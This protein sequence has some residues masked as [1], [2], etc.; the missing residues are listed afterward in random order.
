VLVFS[1][2]RIDKLIDAAVSINLE[3]ESEAVDEASIGPEILAR[4]KMLHKKTGKWNLFPYKLKPYEWV[5]PRLAIKAFFEYQP[6]SH[7]KGK[8]HE[9]LQAAISSDSICAVISDRSRLY[10]DCE[11]LERLVEALWVIRIT[12]L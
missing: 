6:I 4:V 11:H 5:Y 1:F 10:L 2:E 8:L 12:E 7:W 3:K 9:I